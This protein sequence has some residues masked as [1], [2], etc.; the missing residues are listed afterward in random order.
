VATG[1]R[2]RASKS[3]PANRFSWNCHFHQS[4][5]PDLILEFYSATVWR[6]IFPNGYRRASRHSEPKVLE[7]A[8]AGNRDLHCVDFAVYAIPFINLLPRI[9]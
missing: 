8:F 9:E 3:A 4:L 1:A 5:P 6:D 2:F 7:I